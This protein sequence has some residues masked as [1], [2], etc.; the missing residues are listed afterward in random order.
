MMPFL[1]SAMNSAKSKNIRF[2]APET[3][4]LVQILK[5]NMSPEESEKADKIIKLMKERQ[6]G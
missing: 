4:L 2:S 3:E 6:S 5:Q 1:L